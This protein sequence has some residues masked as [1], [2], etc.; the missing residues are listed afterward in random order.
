MVVS[1]SLCTCNVHTHSRASV[2][3][4]PPMLLQG[5]KGARASENSTN[6][7]TNADEEDDEVD[8]AAITNMIKRNEVELFDDTV[9]ADTGP[10]RV[11]VNPL[12]E[13]NIDF[14]QSKVAK[15]LSIP[16]Q[17]YRVSL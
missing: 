10:A 13:E 2:Q 12:A 4:K 1:V 3:C 16:V 7:N 8:I 9:E 17:R 6:E 14:F 11:N 5:N 15:T